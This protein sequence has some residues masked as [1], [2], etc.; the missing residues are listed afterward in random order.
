MENTNCQFFNFNYLD[1]KKSFL[2]R[3]LVGI[4]T[5]IDFPPFSLSLSQSHIRVL[6]TSQETVN[7]LLMG[8]EYLIN[9]SYVDDTEVFKVWPPILSLKSIHLISLIASVWF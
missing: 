6:E 8:L 1:Y 5:D 2:Y 9:I 7:A 4:S 3:N